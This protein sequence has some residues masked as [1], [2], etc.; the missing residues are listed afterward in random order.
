M[1]ITS[2]SN[3]VFKDIMKLKNKKH[4]D[5]KGVFTAEGL[6]FVGEIPEDVFV[7]EYIVSEG[8]ADE[9]VMRKGV[10]V[11]TLAENLFKQLSDTESPQGII[12]VCRKKEV[13]V[14]EALSDKNGLYVIAE[15]I[16][17]PGN[18]GTI[19]RTADAFGAKA[20]VLSK[21]SVDLYNS[22]VLRS[23]MGSLFHLPVITDADIKETIDTLKTNGIKVF[24]AHL[25][26]VKTPAQ[27]DFKCGCAFVFG[28]EARGLE[29]ET[30]SLCDEY[31][32]IPMAGKAE[33][34]NL[35]V[36]A[37]VLMYECL[38]Q[39]TTR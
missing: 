37:S 2:A 33:S 22:K 27:A 30:A 25:K 12:A 5:K 11:Y 39:R 13:D 8:F 10:R 18:L 19:I 35:S 36:A 26:G 38:R 1:V 24:A 14:K 9:D 31:I 16:N 34:L 28:N 4:R 21:G 20:V 15:Q 6:R 23:T 3:A 29:D 17:D 32:K 7:E